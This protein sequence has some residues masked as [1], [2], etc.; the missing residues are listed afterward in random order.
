[1]FNFQAKLNDS[2]GAPLSGS[3]TL[4]FTVILGGDAVTTSSGTAIYSESQVIAVSG[5]VVNHT[6]GS[7]TPIFGSLNPSLYQFNQ[8]TFLQVA[9]DSPANV[10]LPRMAIQ[11]VP[12][13]AKAGTSVASLFGTFGGRGIDGSRTVTGNETLGSLRAE[14]TTLNINTGTTLTVD[15]G[16]AFIAVQGKCQIDGLI[17]ADGQGEAGG[18]PDFSGLGFAGTDASGQVSTGSVVIRCA[19]GAGG[20]GGAGLFTG[21]AGQGGGAQGHG[22][23]GGTAGGIGLDAEASPIQG[24][25][26]AGGVATTI[27]SEATLTDSFS[28]LLLYRGAGG[29]GGTLGF[30]GDNG[31]PGGAGGGVIY[32]ECGELVLSGTGG[33]SAR[34]ADGVTPFGDG[35]AG[36]GGGGG[37]ILVRTR[38]I[39]T[40]AGTVSVAGGNGGYSIDLY[41]GGNGGAGFSDIVQLN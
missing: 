21:P 39:T 11:S 5:G 13:A 38:K 1:M 32:I 27:G 26:L 17:T 22:G 36:G 14:Y 31:Y 15:Q 8:D 34:G 41:F 24:R 2:F 19:S 4:Y 10:T 37:V 23:V 18:G 28:N 3:H 12:F 30:F 7:G 33:L 25:L 9:V 29:G 35:G 40:N 16:W 6:I 20:G